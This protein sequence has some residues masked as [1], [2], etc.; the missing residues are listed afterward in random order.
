[1]LSY[2]LLILTHYVNVGLNKT[3]V[4]VRMFCIINFKCNVYTNRGCREGNR[5]R[6]SLE[7]SILCPMVTN[8]YPKLYTSV[9]VV[10]AYSTFKIFNISL[11]CCLTESFKGSFIGYKFQSKCD[12]VYIWYCLKS[13]VLFRGPTRNNIIIHIYNIKLCKYIVAGSSSI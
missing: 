9:F 13:H 5:V 3:S 4:T 2:C 6:I 12:Y 7:N 10:H 8:L 1:L 11:L